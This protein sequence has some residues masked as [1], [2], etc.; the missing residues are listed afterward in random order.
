MEAYQQES[1]NENIC[2]RETAQPVSMCCESG[3][4]RHG[5][6]ARRDGLPH[7]SLLRLAGFRDELERDAIIAIAL[8]GRRGAV[9]EYMAVMAAAA[10]AVILGA[11]IENLVIGA[12]GEHARDGREE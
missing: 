2:W 10:Y 9:V 3:T 12:G 6:N 5:A 1:K 11:R 4:M 7:S 8:T